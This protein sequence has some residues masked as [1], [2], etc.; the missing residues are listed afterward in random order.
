MVAAL[1]ILVSDSS[2][3]IWACVR[4]TLHSQWNSLQGSDG[5]DEGWAAPGMLLLTHGT[6]TEPS[7]VLDHAEVPKRSKVIR[8]IRQIM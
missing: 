5:S 7:T 4:T 2:S 1:C 8:D 3:C 6:A